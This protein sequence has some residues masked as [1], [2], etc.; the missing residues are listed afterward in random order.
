M[1]SLV[2]CLVVV[3]LLTLPARAA[4]NTYHIFYSLEA[5]IAE[6]EWVFHGSIVKLSRKVVVD[7]SPQGNFPNGVAQYTISVAVD[8]V[9]KGEPPEQVQLVR[10]ADGLD[11]RLEQ[12][13]EAETA[14]L[15]FVGR[16]RT[17]T[18]FSEGHRG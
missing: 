11:K 9:L 18:F 15:W 4:A 16:G 3:L 6:A 12:W 1:S 14:F 7:P 5:R 13:H 2:R 10:G 8:K 17:A